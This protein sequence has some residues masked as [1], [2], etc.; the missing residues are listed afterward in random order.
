MWS[1][2]KLSDEEDEGMMEEAR[3]PGGSEKVTVMGKREVAGAQDVQG[4][5]TFRLLEDQ[6]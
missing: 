5:A 4:A 6:P 2:W 1:W 3:K